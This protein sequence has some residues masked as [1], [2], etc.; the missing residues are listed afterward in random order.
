MS[1]PARTPLKN[2]RSSGGRRLGDRFIA[3]EIVVPA[4]MMS[5]ID[6]EKEVNVVRR[7][8]WRGGYIITEERRVHNPAFD[9]RGEKS[10]TKIKIRP[11][12]TQGEADFVMSKLIGEGS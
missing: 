7:N 9:K 4:P 5:E 6:R 1:P 11:V 8:A 2:P 12:K 3:S 10:T